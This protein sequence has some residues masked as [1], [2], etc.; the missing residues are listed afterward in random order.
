L[1]ECLADPA[2]RWKTR[3]DWSSVEVF[4]GDERNVPPD[5]ANSN[6]G[7]AHRA[8]IQHVEIPAQHIHRMRGELSAVEAARE[9]DALLH[10]RARS[11]DLLFDIVL[12]GIGTDAHIASLFPHSP[13]LAQTITQNEGAFQHPESRTKTGRELASGVFV[14]AVRQWRITLTPPAVLSA[15]SI[16]VL[17]AGAEK[18]DAVANAI[19]GDS[20]IQRYPAQLLRAAGER[21]EWII[22]EAAARQLS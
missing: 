13:L 14:P 12:L 15:R 6:F 4:W 17:A 11:D 18:A 21:V 19:E 7:L 20:E 10:N 2:G 22:D 8:L 9:Y 1:Y 5:D 3:I 16:V